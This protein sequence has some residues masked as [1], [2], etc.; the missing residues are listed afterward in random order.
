MKKDTF[1]LRKTFLKPITNLTDAQLGRLFKAIY[2]YQC[3]EKP[4]LTDDIAVHFSYFEAEFKAEEEKRRRRAEKA[5]ERRR[6]K[7]EEAQTAAEPQPAHET[8]EPEKPSGINVAEYDK[9]M[10]D[11]KIEYTDLRDKIRKIHP[12]IYKLGLSKLSFDDYARLRRH[13]SAQTFKSHVYDLSKTYDPKTSDM[14]Y[15][16]AMMQHIISRNLRS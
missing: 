7:L 3:G 11:L 13:I 1:S 9:K 4:E 5:A 12:K 2:Q 6:K 8:A 14:T 10:R 15:F 16:Q